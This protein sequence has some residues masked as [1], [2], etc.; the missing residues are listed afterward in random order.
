MKYKIYAIMILSTVGCSSISPLSLLS[1]NKPSIEV[2]AQ[3]AKHATLE[4]SI[5]S[6]SSGATEQT[7]DTISNDTKQEADLITNITQNIPLEYLAI[8]IMLA[9]WLIPS[10]KEC[11]TGAKWLVVDLFDSLVKTPIKGLANFILVLIGREKL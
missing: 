5:I 10:P 9:G 4:K 3:V 2:N 11:Y 1:P 8:V 7:A 6:A